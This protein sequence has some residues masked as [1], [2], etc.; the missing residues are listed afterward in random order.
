MS[1]RATPARRGIDALIFGAFGVFLLFLTF[2]SALGDWKSG[3]GGVAMIAYAAY[4]AF[5]R[6]TYWVSYQI[7]ALAIVAVIILGFMA[8]HNGQA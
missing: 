1:F 3:L 2:T 8:T 5:G 7:Y 4:I 6:R